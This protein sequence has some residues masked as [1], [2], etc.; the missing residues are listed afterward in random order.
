MLFVTHTIAEAVFLS[1]RVAMMGR[2][3]GSIVEIVEIDLPRPRSLAMRET[4]AFSRYMAHIRHHF[5][6]L[7]I[8]KE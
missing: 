5:A 3:P 4:A 7:G 8:V 6:E 1:D 2:A